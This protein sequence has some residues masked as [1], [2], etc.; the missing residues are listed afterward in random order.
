MKSS[1][2]WNTF[3]PTLGTDNFGFSALPGGVRRSGGIFFFIRD[4]A[5]ILSA[6]EDG[7][8]YAWSR[9]LTNSSSSMYRGDGIN[10]SK[11]VGASVRCLRD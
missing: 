2:L 4:R 7:S 10:T 6:T 3:P 8:N 1:T 11:S 5:F 9:S